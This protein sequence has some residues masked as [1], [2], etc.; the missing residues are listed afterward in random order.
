MPLK[1]YNS[2]AHNFNI[3]NLKFKDEAINSIN[4][5]GQNYIDVTTLKK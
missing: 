2:I 5:L 3:V 1:K 4:Y